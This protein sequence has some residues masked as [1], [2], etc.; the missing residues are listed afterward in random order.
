MNSK[1]EYNRCALPRL[2]LKIG[3]KEYS[4]AK[5]ME[6]QEEQTE[7]NIE[8]KIRILRKQAGKKTNRSSKFE[9]PAAKRQKT[10]NGNEYLEKR[11]TAM[12]CYLHVHT[13]TKRRLGNSRC[14][15]LIA[16]T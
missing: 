4:K 7:R 6:D 3:T 16:L 1:S 5:E 10:N 14:L 11:K 13:H 9:N 2:G 12:K 15:H 8:E